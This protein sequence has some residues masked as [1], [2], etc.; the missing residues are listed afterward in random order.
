MCARGIDLASFYDFDIYFG[1]V[2]TVWHSFNFVTYHRLCNRSNTTG[3]NR[4]TGT[5][6]HTGTHE[7]I[8]GFSGI[9]VAHQNT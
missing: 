8:P 9:R 5:A 4:E 2:S 6:Y 1:T 3:A 7:L